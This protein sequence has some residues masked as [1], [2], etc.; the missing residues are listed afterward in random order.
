MIIVLAILTHDKVF[1]I[2]NYY[3]ICAQLMETGV[4]CSSQVCS[5]FTEPMSFVLRKLVHMNT[6][7]VTLVGTSLSDCVCMQLCGLTFVRSGVSDRM[8]SGLFD[9]AFVLAYLPP[10]IRKHI[11]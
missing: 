6:A 9:R 3:H 2:V 7:I 1:Q 5:G 8:R 10:D 4:E 11:L